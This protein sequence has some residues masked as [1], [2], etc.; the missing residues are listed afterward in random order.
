VY[1]GALAVEGVAS[2]E[3][4]ADWEIRVMLSFRTIACVA[5]GCVTHDEAKVMIQS[6]DM[7]AW[8]MANGCLPL[9]RDL[10]LVSLTT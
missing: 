5:G 10:L 1:N 2:D 6:L 4:V 8:S 7:R 9:L 3:V